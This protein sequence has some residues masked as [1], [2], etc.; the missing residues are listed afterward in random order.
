MVSKD[1]LV[2]TFLELVKIDSPSGQEAEV[3][4]FLA[5]KLEKLG[6]KAEF[7]SY[8]NLIVHF[9]GQGEPMM[10]NA[11]M[12]TVEPGRGIKPIVEGEIIKTDGTTVLGGDPKA[13]VAAIIEALTSIKEGGKKHLPIEVVLTRQEELGMIGARN[14]DYSKVKAKRGVTFDGGEESHKVDISSPGYQRVDA[15][16][17]GR[18]AHA[19]AEPEKGI[20]AIKIAAE[21]ISKLNLGRIDEET[22]AN[23]GLIE[24]GSVRNA[25]PEKVVIRGEIRSRDMQKLET[26]TKHFEEV[27]DGVMKNYPEANLEL[28]LEKEFNSY[29]F[30]ENH[31]VLEHIKRGFETLGVTPQLHHSGGGT[32][33]NIFHTHGIE[34][35]VVGD[36][37][38]NAH[39]TREY[40]DINQMLLAA[41]FAE[42]LIE[43]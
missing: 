1:R 40:V 34:A 31:R 28:E 20:S 39:T 19:G 41:Q 13:G 23:I 27:F 38:Y 9:S 17:V 12:D 8:G 16:I 36:G 6:G 15:I 4:K 10:L 3:A 33:V 30:N 42:K 43:V 26:H 32:D 14:L 35:L 29:R 24:G 22:T 2:K 18:A 21:I 25:V 7:D 5:R 37:D 11:H